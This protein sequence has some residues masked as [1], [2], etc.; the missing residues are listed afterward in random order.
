GGFV[1]QYQI[2]VDPNRLLALDVSLHHMFN[3]VKNSNIDVGAKVIEESGA[4]FIVRGLGF[5]ESIED[6]ENIVIGSHQGVPVYVKNVGEVTLG[7]DF[8]RGALDKEG[9]EVT[10]GVVLMRYGENPLEAIEGIKEK[11]EEI[12]PGLPPGVQIVSFY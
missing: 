11:I 4:E 8:R 7:P 12:T 5:I 6:I 2:D 1:R 3:A 10:G 9:A